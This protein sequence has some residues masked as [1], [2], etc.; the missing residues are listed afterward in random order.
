MRKELNQLEAMGLIHREHGWAMIGPVTAKC[1]ELFRVDKLFILTDTS[2]FARRG[3]IEMM[4]LATVSGVYTDGG[5]PPEFE[6]ELMA[7]TIDV[8]KA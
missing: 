4:P 6:A 3:V 7:H 2:K 8:H 1:C 5:I